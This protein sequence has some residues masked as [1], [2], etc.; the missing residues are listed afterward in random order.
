M[1]KLIQVMIKEQMNDVIKEA[2]KEVI[3]ELLLENGQQEKERQEKGL[4][5][6]A[7]RQSCRMKKTKEILENPFISKNVGKEYYTEEII[8]TT[9]EFLDREISEKTALNRLNMTRYDF[10]KIWHCIAFR[11]LYPTNR[12]LY[13]HILERV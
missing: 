7:D 11:Y 6:L 12:K 10:M 5:Y 4:Q 1:E 2:I 9:L 3:K 13:S 8:Y